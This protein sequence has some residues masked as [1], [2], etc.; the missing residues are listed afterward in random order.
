MQK[1][2]ES[3][4]TEVSR[5]YELANHILT[6]GLDVL[7]RKK[8]AR[9]GARAGGTLWLDVC[10][11]TGEMARNLSFLAPKKVKI[12]ALDFCQ[13]MLTKIREKKSRSKISLV[14][15]EANPLPFAPN[16]FDL[17]AISFA[18][19]N[20][21]LSR[22]AL[23]RNFKEFLRVLKPGGSLVNLE[24]SQPQLGIVQRL[25]HYYIRSVVLPVGFFISG[26]KAGYRYLSSTIPRFYRPE[27]LSHFL[28][29]ARFERVTFKRLFFGIAAIHTAIK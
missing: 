20:L 11:G 27:E 3:I 25:F 28:Q 13:S 29:E 23:L 4:F 22:E 1:N 24:T 18:T 7:W 9:E 2:I 6:F 15:A 14:L 21:N 8:A 10:S 5:T 17:V 16:T 19:R 26:S 12:I